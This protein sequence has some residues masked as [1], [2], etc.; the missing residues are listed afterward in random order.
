MQSG[1]NIQVYK[2]SPLFSICRPNDCSLL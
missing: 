2:S 1:K